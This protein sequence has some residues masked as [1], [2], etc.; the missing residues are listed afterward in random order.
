MNF[1][2]ISVLAF[3]V[4]ILCS[5]SI[6]A[7]NKNDYFKFRPQSLSPD[8]PE[9]ASL[10][11]QDN[12]NVNEVDALYRT[13]YQ[14]HPFVKNVHSQNYKFWKKAI[15][16]K[17]NSQGFI[18]EASQ[19]EQTAFYDQLK[20]Q[21]EEI[22]NNPQK[23]NSSSWQSL[24]PFETYDNGTLTPIS[25]QVNIYSL[26]ISNTNT[27]KLIAGTEAGGVFLSNDKGL[28]W[29]LISR[30]EVFC[31]NISAVKFHPTNNNEMLIS[32]NN[33]IYRSTDNGLSW[34]EVEFT[35]GSIYEFKF[36]PANA[37]NVFA[38]GSTG[39]YK[40]TDSGQN[41]TTVYSATC[42]DL[43][44]HPNN[45][46]IAYLLK[47]NSSQ[48]K[49]EFLKSIDGG[50]TWNVITNGWYAPEVFSEAND[51]GGKIAIS[52]A[53]PDRV[54]VALVGDSKSGD[55][56]WIGL[57]RSDD[58]GDNWTLPSGQIGGPYGSPNTAI[59]NPASYTD[60][61][62]QGYY[63]F[64]LEAS[65]SDPDKLWM[66]TVRL[67]ETSD[68]GQSFTGIG[69][70]NNIRLERVHADIQAIEVVGNEI[71][72]A[73]DG[74]INY[75]TDEL[76][77][78]ESRKKGIIGSEFWGF[79]AGWNDDVLVGGK[80]HN[81]NS[82]F[83]QTYGTGQ[84]HHVG[85][86]EESTGYVNPLIN[87]RTYFNRYWTNETISLKLADALGGSTQSEAS[88]DFIPN[89]HRVAASGLYFD[90]RYADHIY[91]GSGS[92]LY[93]S[94]NGGSSFVPLHD[95]G[96]SGLIYEIEI[97][98]SNPD[99]LYVSFQ[100][101]GGYWDWHD[102]YKS[103]DGGST[104]NKLTDVPTDRWRIQIT[105]NPLDENE[106]WVAA[107]GGSNGSQVFQT[108]DSGNSWINQSNSLLNGTN[109]N[110]IFYQAGSN[111]VY[112]L[113]LNGGVYYCDKTTGNWTDYSADLPTISRGMK[114][115]PFYKE[116]KLRIATE[117]RG[118]WEVD[119]AQSSSVIA[120]AITETDSVFCSR[121]TVQ[122]DSYSIVDQSNV[123]WTWNINPS[124]DFIE[125][126]SMRNPKVVFGNNG[127]Y[128]VSLTVTSPS[129]SDT[130]SM[131]EMVYVDS[132]CDP[133]TIPGM[134]LDL[135]TDGDFV[136][137]PNLNRASTEELTISAWVKLNGIQNDYSS[138]VMNDG[139]AAGLN[140][141][142]GNNTLGYHWP[143]GQ[144]WWNSNLV[145]PDGEWAH[146]AM[147]VSPGKVVLYLNGKE[148]IHN[149]NISPA[150]INSMKVGS[151]LGWNGR[152]MNGQ[153]DEVVIWDRALTTDEIRTH[154]HLTKEDLIANG[155]DV[156]LY[157]QFNREGTKIMD[158]VS[159]E[160]AS[161]SGNAQKIE[162]SAPVG[163]GTSAKQNVDATSNYIFGDTGLDL[164]FTG[165]S[166]L[167]NGDVY[168]SRINLLPHNAL[169][170]HEQISC[171]WIINNYGLDSAD[172]PS[173]M[174]YNSPYSN[175]S[176]LVINDPTELALFNRTENDFQNNWVDACG[177]KEA[178]AG[179]SGMY[180][181]ENPCSNKVSGQYFI[182]SGIAFQAKV[183]LEGSYLNNG[184][185]QNDLGPLIPLNQ[186]YS[187][188][189]YNYSG[190][191][192]LTSLPV[193]MVDW[194][195]VEAREGM[196]NI[197][198]NRATTT[199]ETKAGILLKD[200]SI[201]S[202]DGIS[203]L[204]FENLVYDSDYY[205]CI[206]HR[207][208]LDILSSAALRANAQMF[209]DFT[210]D[211]N[212]ALGI[213][214][215]KLASDGKS[216]MYGGE[217]TQDGFIQVTDYDLWKLNPAILNSYNVEDGNLDGVTQT[218]DFDLWVPNKAKIGIAEIDY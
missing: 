51:G 156:I 129:G 27:S 182:N 142:G 125:S 92:I 113:S 123:S 17:V 168:V 68:G 192:S 58:T 85:G 36:D 164:N 2:K 207:N 28:N 37:N 155:D 77:S 96:Q 139:V 61:Y 162:S 63:N 175:P 165:N 26:D 103:S 21:K 44:F 94:E 205:F 184:E 45:A 195:L 152:N 201:V 25:W 163:G 202:T 154:R 105:V 144:W 216:V 193:D 15:A 197:S 133:D 33:R 78:H 31:T 146:C 145:V 32:G 56:G 83:Y 50:N 16:S 72:V 29:D 69:G 148:A 170:D 167:P 186:V 130:Y 23:A 206:R 64:D 30:D 158:R 187:S 46:D 127:A 19:A 111:L 76:M 151:Y 134:A 86:V 10:M 191:E 203:P 121:D 166:N 53:A 137:I 150:D 95:F 131:A 196:P 161:L 199:V 47:S 109:P 128:D 185:M 4:L 49:S 80:Y 114:M 108:T 14:S 157:Y 55:N 106:L 198:G 214:Q 71:W 122:F 74:G 62:H 48:K 110:D 211:Q 75:S 194:I 132:A 210:T 84:Y 54:Y 18:V 90:K 115:L 178:T 204:R 116:N 97:P 13:F 212:A 124:P 217:Y 209:I 135:L 101:N 160:H 140:F 190:S 60:G 208:H 5:L 118:I 100:P 180:N 41:W 59:W 11:Y 153:I 22:L 34:N 40:S 79:G 117:G 88:V 98:F 87:R 136:Q 12:P 9:W 112:V 42:W 39:M 57:Y 89:E 138:I 179:N 147:T 188:A 200:G 104:W 169:N 120:Q 107:R 171:Y 183:Y 172:P 215:L 38:V 82:A 3:L 213:E 73:S 67:S 119:L 149:I 91:A 99:V 65:N 93:K 218:T 102:I 52:P 24:G 181:Y 173:L 174:S 43:D 176:E 177:N 143:D 141:R 7:Q 35:S 159:S 8:C 126:A 20:N 189:P 66:G 1:L 6:S 70:A 81:G